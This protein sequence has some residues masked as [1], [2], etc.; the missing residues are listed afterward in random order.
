MD[1][2]ETVSR[3]V[4]SGD[5]Q[6][7]AGVFVGDLFGR[8][9]MGIDVPKAESAGVVVGLFGIRCFLAGDLGEFVETRDV[10]AAGRW[11]KGEPGLIAE[12]FQFVFGV[13]R[14]A[15]GDA[16][17]SKLGTVGGSVRVGDDD[18]DVSVR[19][20]FVGDFLN[21]PL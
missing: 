21:F 15:D 19:K 20:K 12:R 2:V 8:G 1:G 14:L 11:A 18:G 7:R 4:K 10:D 9:G 5:D 17:Q 6:C 16:E 13:Y 3:V